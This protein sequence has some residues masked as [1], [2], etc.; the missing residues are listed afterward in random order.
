M[1]QHLVALTVTALLGLIA[2]VAFFLIVS[3]RSQNHA[4]APVGA[5]TQHSGSASAPSNLD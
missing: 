4:P 1:R 5:K 3:A 2:V